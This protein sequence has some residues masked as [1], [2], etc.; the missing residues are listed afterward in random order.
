MMFNKLIVKLAERVLSQGQVAVSYEEACG[1]ARLP[2]SETLDLLACSHKITRAAKSR[3]LIL[4]SILNAKSG[5][6]TEDC[7]FCAQSSHHRTN[8]PR[9]DLETEEAMVEAARV[10]HQAGATHYSMVTSG[11]MLT[12]QEI[13]AVCG[14][15]RRVGEETGMKVCASL[16]TLTPEKAARL[17]ESGITT[18]HHNLET[19]RSF[20]DQVCTTHA[21]D[22]DIA[23]LKIVRAAGLKVCSGGIM[24][25]GESWEQR[26]E[27]ACT[28]R[29]LDVDRIPL[30][31]LN[32]IPETRMENR[33]LLPPLEALKCIALLRFINPEKD[34]LICGGREV[35][36]K[37]FQSWIFFAGANG[38]LVG[39]YLTTQGRDARQD[40]EMI[41]DFGLAAA[42]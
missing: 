36:L 21:Y 16:G 18:Y 40:R 35:T 30:N 32:P 22:E 2:E 10:R 3:E 39:N 14:A 8:I 19:A 12:D 34:I 31:F 11:L 23:T 6:C 1:L 38:V 7:A 41:Q 4:C 29:E 26:V 13:A 27:F 5:F 17:R 20:F 15:G 37:D 9:Y 33:P 25:L 28:L 24:G 42:N